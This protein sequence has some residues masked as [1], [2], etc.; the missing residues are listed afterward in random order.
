PGACPRPQWPVWT[1][2]SDREPA[3]RTIQAILTT[4]TPTPYTKLIP[5][6]RSGIPKIVTATTTAVAAPAIAHQCGFT[7]SPASNPNST[8]IGRAATT[9]E[10]IQLCSGSYTWVHAMGHS[11]TEGT[12]MRNACDVALIMLP[13][14]R[15][16]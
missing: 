5:A 15:L 3:A 2:T 14:G 10:R 16:R 9:V 6:S 12:P 7:L 13:P 8:R 1:D 11:S 4:P